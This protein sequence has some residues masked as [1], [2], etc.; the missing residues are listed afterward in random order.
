VLALIARR[1]VTWIDGSRNPPTQPG[2]HTSRTWRYLG[3]PRHCYGVPTVQQR[4]RPTA[5]PPIGVVRDGAGL[6]RPARVLLVLGPGC[7]RDRHPGAGGRAR[8]RAESP[9]PPH[10]TRSDHTSLVPARVPL[11][12]HPPRGCAPPPPMNGPAPALFIGLPVTPSGG[13]ARVPMLAVGPPR[14][15]AATGNRHPPARPCPPDHRAVRGRYGTVHPDRGGCSTPWPPP[16][17][18]NPCGHPPILPRAWRAA[19]DIPFPSRP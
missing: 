9:A 1:R 18:G 12:H 13:Q 4:G 19:C 10:N 11:G 7:C 16:T 5:E 6:L 2:L 14:H 17:T 3:S 8:R 15:T